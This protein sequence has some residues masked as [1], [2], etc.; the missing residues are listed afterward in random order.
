MDNEV[1]VTSPESTTQTLPSFKEFTPPVTYPKEVE[2]TLG[3]PIEVEPLDETPLEDLGLNTYNHDIPFNSREIPSIDEPEPQLQPLT[4]C[5]SSDISLG[6][7]KG[8]EPPIKPHN[9]DSFRMKVVDNLTIHTPPSP[10]MASSH[11]KDTYCYYRPCIDDPKKHYVF[12]P[13]LLGHSGSL[14]VDFSNMEMIEYDWGLESKE[15][16][17]KGKGLNSLIRPKEV[18]KPEIR[19]HILRQCYSAPTSGWHHGYRNYCKIVFEAGFLQAKYLRGRR[20]MDFYGTFPSSNRNKYILVGIDY[21][22]KWVEAQAFSTNDARNVVN[23]L[24]KLFA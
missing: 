23:F 24:K 13:G 16:S 17:F 9:S 21:V 5:P 4:N 8:P 14:G 15:V 1:G 6:E 10:H 7:E 12:K 2:E 11:P 20:R 22:S 3:I 19:Q 18:E